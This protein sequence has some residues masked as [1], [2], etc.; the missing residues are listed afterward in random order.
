MSQ[1]VHPH[2]R[3][4]GYR[5]HLGDLYG[6]LANNMAA[7]YFSGLA[8]HDQFAET[9]LAPVD[10]CARGRVEAE[11]SRSRHRAFHGPLLR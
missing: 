8:V 2:P 4:D 1:L 11:Q 5:R 10:D 6:S 9:D 3:G 7:Q